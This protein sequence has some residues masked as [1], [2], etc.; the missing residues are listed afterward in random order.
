METNNEK[1][2]EK[3]IPTLIC[4][5]LNGE[6]KHY[7]I[8]HCRKQFIFFGELVPTFECGDRW[9]YHS[10]ELLSKNDIVSTRS[11]YRES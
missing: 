2:N 6:V 3:N 4:R 10:C 1:N 8:G 7:D 9:N 11:S 5:H